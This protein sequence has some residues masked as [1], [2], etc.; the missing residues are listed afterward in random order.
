MCVYIACACAIIA[1]YKM[2]SLLIFESCWRRFTER[3]GMV[4]CAILLQTVAA[5]H[6]VVLLTHMAD[7]HGTAAAAHMD[8]SYV[9][10]CLACSSFYRQFRPCNITVVLCCVMRRTF[11]SHARSYG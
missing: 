6:S 4:R 1:E 7:L 11:A 9:R 8:S 2:E 10:S 3:Y 5:L